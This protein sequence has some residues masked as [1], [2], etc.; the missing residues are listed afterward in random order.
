[1]KDTV[2]IN[3]GGCKVTLLGDY[4]HAEPRF[5]RRDESAEPSFYIEKVSEIDGDLNYLI[6]T[7]RA[8]SIQEGK[9]KYANVWDDL[10]ELALEQLMKSKAA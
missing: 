8:T 7:I 10:K 3:Y 1:M 9:G 2:T 4:T 5:G 6:E